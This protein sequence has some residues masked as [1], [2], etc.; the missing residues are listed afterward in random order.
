MQARAPRGREKPLEPHLGNSRRLLLL[1]LLVSARMQH[2][3]QRGQAHTR[4]ILPYQVE[5]FHRIGIMRVCIARASVHAGSVR[6][7]SGSISPCALQS[8]PPHHDDLG[9][10]VGRLDARDVAHRAHLLARER[11]YLI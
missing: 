10:A 9:R 7:S 3:R 11:L 6:P 2:T 5:S 8:S 1:L 4:Q